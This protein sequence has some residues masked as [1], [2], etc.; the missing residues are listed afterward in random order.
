VST[1]EKSVGLPAPRRWTL[2]GLNNGLIFS[3][4]YHGVRLL[5]RRL[6]YAIG[7]VGTWLAW[8]LMTTTRAALADNLVPLFPTEDRAT[9]ER[10][11]LSTFRCYARDMIDFLR[12]L[13]APPDE[14]QHL[15]IDTEIHR[16][17]FESI[18]ARGRGMILVTGHYGNWEIGSVLIRRAL[19][20]PLT[21][22]AMSEPSP[23]VNRIRREIRE[24]LGA[25]TIEVRQSIDTA[26]K[27][28][29]CLTDNRI[30]AMLVDRHFGRDRV[31][32]TFFGRDA[33]VLRT[34]LLM[35]HATGAPLVPC[36]IERTEPGRFIPRVGTPIFLETRVPRDDAIARGAQQIA[37]DLEHRVRAHP[38]FWYHFYKYWDAQRDDY[39]G[40]H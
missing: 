37:T 18:L 8:R 22:V 7:H 19:S 16:P 1:I 15:F 27:I 13:G 39:D 32:V 38:E 35:A 30:V 40:L 5:P 26:L 23:T 31:P 2:H 17:L 10:R 24:S 28:R 20:M 36:F 21:I 29:R 4:T 9:L 14:E 11:A 25:H 33:W 3:A 12:A 6:S 34:P